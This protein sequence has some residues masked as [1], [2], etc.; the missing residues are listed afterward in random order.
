MEKRILEPFR[1]LVGGLK[2]GKE[3]CKRQIKKRN[4]S[5]GGEVRNL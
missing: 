5:T 1:R 4:N 3:G 2:G